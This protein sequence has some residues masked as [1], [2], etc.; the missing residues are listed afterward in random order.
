MREIGRPVISRH[1]RRGI[2]ARR[3]LFAPSSVQGSA[4]RRDL[5]F[6]V[7]R[8]MRP[9]RK[10]GRR[11]APSVDGSPGAMMWARAA[12][13]RS[14]MMYSPPIGL[15]PARIRLASR[16]SLSAILLGDHRPCPWSHV[17]GRRRWRQ[18]PKRMVSRPRPSGRGAATNWTLPPRSDDLALE[19]LEV[20]IE[21][22]E[23]VVS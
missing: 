9:R 4:A 15:D 6:G 11:P 22:G 18:D 20:E 3:D 1:R 14:W 12:R 13:G 21:M 10:G 2:S 17:L 19:F 5:R 23:R 7:E 16:K 8:G